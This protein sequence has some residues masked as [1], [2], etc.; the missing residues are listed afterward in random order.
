MHEYKIKFSYRQEESGKRIYEYEYAICT[1]A[2][3]A[4]ESVLDA[5]CDLSRLRIEQI[6]IDRNNRWE[7]IEWE[8]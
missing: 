1:T 8:A 5:Y 6:W 3:E 4:V 7:I 2:R